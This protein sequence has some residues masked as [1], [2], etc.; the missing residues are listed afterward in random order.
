MADDIKLSGRADD[1][2]VNGIH[3]GLIVI[4][5]LFNF[6]M[7]A[8]CVPLFDLERYDLMLSF[9]FAFL[10][11]GSFNFAMIRTAVLFKDFDKA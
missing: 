3:T 1:K 11:I 2:L 8:S 9:F 4:L 6:C 7:C 10:V 5:V